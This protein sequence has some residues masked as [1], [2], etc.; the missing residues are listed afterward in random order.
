MSLHP[1]TRRSFLKTSTLAASAVALRGSNLLAQTTQAD[2]HIDILPGRAD[3]HDLAGDLFAL[4]RASWWRDLRRRLGRRRLEDSQP[5]GHSQ[6]LHRHHAGG[7]GAGASLARRL[8]CRQ[9]R[10]AR[11]H[12]PR[13]EASR[14]YRLLEPAGP[15]HV[16]LARVHATPAARSAANPTL[17]PICGSLPARDFYQEIEYCNAPAGD[18]PSNSAAKAATKCTGRLARGQWRSRALRRR[19]VG[20]RQ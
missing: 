10:L 14:P 2:A 19:S 7:Q 18:V 17:P 9:L 16:R 20:C 3:R 8:L 4:H 6:G 5:N 13:G 12:R 15:E 1:T 11:W